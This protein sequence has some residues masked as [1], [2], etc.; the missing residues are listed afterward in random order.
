MNA[1]INGFLS[2]CLTLSEGHDKIQRISNHYTP[3]FIGI[4]ILFKMVLER[5]LL[6]M[7]I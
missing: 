1:C 4:S 3:I 2:V 5:K 7:N 6:P